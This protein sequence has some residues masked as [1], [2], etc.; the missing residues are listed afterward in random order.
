MAQSSNESQ[1]NLAIQAIQKDPKITVRRAAS[2]F[3]VAESTVRHRMNGR[4]ARRDLRANNSRLS[5]LEEGTLI[6]YILDLDIRGFT[7]RLRDIKDIANIIIESRDVL[8][9]GTR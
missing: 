7:P 4:S 1:I 5:E 8:Y 2:I 3:N 6:R 9:I